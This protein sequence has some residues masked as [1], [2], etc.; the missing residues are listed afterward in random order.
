MAGYSDVSFT[1]LW[2]RIGG[3]AD[4]ALRASGKTPRGVVVALPEAERAAL[5]EQ[6]APHLAAF[7]DLRHKT[8]ATVDSRARLLVPLAG[9]AAVVGVLLGGLG[10]TAAVIFGALAALAGWFVAMGN[11]SANYQTEV[12]SRFATVVSGHLSGFDHVVEPETDLARLRGWYLFPELQSART[13]DRI[14]GRR[15]GRSLSLSE[16]SIVYA[17]G[18]R[19][20]LDHSFTVSAVEVASDAVDGAMLVLTPHDAPPRILEA[21]RRAA[22]LLAIPTGDSEFDA[23]YCLRSNDPEAGRLLGTDLRAAVLDLNKA[24]PAGR[25]CLVFLPGYLAV[26]FP[27]TFTDYAFH[28]PPYWV[29]L[30]ADALLAQF[31]SDL[32]LKNSLINAVLGLPDEQHPSS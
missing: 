11:R 15:N 1:A 3:H 8:L 23:A 32:A 5:A 31:A 27:T 25:P 19:G 30:D 21:Q 29:S 28:V 17:P 18:R 26:L 13:L 9:G 16:M 12:K 22:D 24:G 7:E 4:A 2:A 14:T 20:R 6:I 10:L